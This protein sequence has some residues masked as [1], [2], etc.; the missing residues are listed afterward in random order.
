VQAVHYC[1]EIDWRVFIHPA[2]SSVMW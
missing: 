1:I 2:G